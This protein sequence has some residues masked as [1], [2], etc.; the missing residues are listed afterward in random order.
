MINLVKL[1]NVRLEKTNAKYKATTD[2][3]RRV[4]IFNDC[5]PVIVYLKKDRF[6]VGNYLKLQPH[7][8]SYKI[9]KKINNNAYVVDLPQ[10]MEISST[11]S[12]T[13]L[14]VFHENN[15]LY[16]EDNLGSSFSKVKETDVQHMV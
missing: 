4:N 8:A 16:P 10:S 12:V 7:Y 3:H 11:F 6:R 15:L 14:Y 1:S 2:K 5:D 9:L 13:D